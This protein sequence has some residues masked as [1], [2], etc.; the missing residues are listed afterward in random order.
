MCGEVE[1][2]TSC[3]SS[4]RGEVSRNLGISWRRMLIILAMGVVVVV[5]AVTE[6]ESKVVHIYE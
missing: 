5:Q 6:A 3:S 2:K 4:G 1:R